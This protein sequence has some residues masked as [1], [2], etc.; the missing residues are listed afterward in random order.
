[1]RV[2]VVLVLER[3]H[4]AIA[5]FSAAKK[6]PPLPPHHRVAPPKGRCAFEFYCKQNVP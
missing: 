3:Q 4:G 2:I 1:V 5:S 6:D